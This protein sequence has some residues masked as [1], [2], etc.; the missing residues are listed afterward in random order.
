[1]STDMS[2]EVSTDIN[3]DDTTRAAAL[4][5]AGAILRVGAVARDDADTLTARTYTHPALDDRRVVRLVAGTLGEAEDL[6]LDFLGLAREPDAPEVGQVRR[7]TLG[8]PAWALVNDPANGHHALALV[9][10]MERLARQAK[11][12][13]GAAKDGFEALATRLG[14][15]VPH[16]LPTFYEQAA[17]VFLQHDNSTYA[18]TLFG[19]ARAAER[20]HGLPVDEE[21]Q[22]AVFLEFAFAGALTVKALKDHAQDLSRRLAPAEAWAQFRQLAVE[23][24]GAGMAPYAALPQDARALIKAADLDRETAESAFVGDLIASPSIVRAPASFW[25]AYRPTLV[26]LAAARPEIRIRLL[27]IMPA[28][29]G[30]D[31]KADEAWLSLLAETGADALLTDMRSTDGVDPADW[32]SRWALHRKHGSSS[33]QRCER[34]LALVER[35][36][37]RLRADGRPADLFQGRW[38]AGADLDLLDACVAW[39]IP[40]TEPAAGA[41]VHL[42]LER[43]IGDDTPGRRDLTA[44]AGRPRFRGLLYEALN[45]LNGH[46]TGDSVLTAIAAHPVLGAVLHDWLRD[47]AAEL[48]GA[49]GLPGSRAALRRLSSFRAVAGQ[50]NPEA[51]AAIA[52]YDLAPVLA[53][54]LRAGVLDELGWPALEETYRRLDAD[55]A[56]KNHW[57][58]VA[59]AWPALVLAN[60]HTA[61][62]VGPEGVLLEHE[63]RLPADLDHWRRPHFRYTDGELLVIWA[64]DGKQRA[65]WSTRPAEPFTL[66]GEQLPQWWNGQDVDF[67]SLPL[68]GGGRATG[69][70]TLHAGDTTLPSTR[71]VLGD[72]TGHWR[73]GRQGRD[74]CWVEYDPAGGTHGRASL[75][76]F[77]Q[78]GIRDGA[79]LVTEE[80]EVLPLLPG[81]EA[82]PLGTD[83]TVLG[84]WVRI[85]GEDPDR[86]VT[87]GTPDGRTVTLAIASGRR[88]HPVPLG[89]LRLPG[90]AAPLAALA[91]GTIE[92]YPEGAVTADALG[93]VPLG[94]R[95]G[96]YAAGTRYVPPPAFWHALRPRDER[97]SAALRTVTDAQIATLLDTVATALAGRKAAVA[98]D[99]SYDGPTAD[100]LIETAVAAALPALTDARLLTGVSALVRT[101]AHHRAATAAYATPPQPPHGGK[102]FG[103]GM[104]A[105]HRPVHGDDATLTAAVDGIAAPGGYRYWGRDEKWSGLQQI[106]SVNQVLSGK[107]ADGKPLPEPTALPALGDGWTTETHTVPG[108]DLGWL[109]FLDALGALAYRA[110]APTTTDEHREALLLLLEAVATG[111]LAN[112]V[113]ALRQVLL[114]E[115]D[116]EDQAGK[117]QR[118]GQVLRRGDRTVVILGREHT[119]RNDRVHWLALDHDPEGEFGQIADFTHHEEQ[120]HTPALPHERL[121][122]LIRLVRERGAA[123]WR[124]EA[125]LTLDAATGIGPAQATLLVA[126]GTGEPHAAALELTGLKARQAE[127]AHDRLSALGAANRLALLDALLPAAPADLWESGPDTAAAA[128]TWAE[129]LASLVRLPEDL[130]DVLAGVTIASAEAVLNPDRTAWLSRTTV[131]RLDKDGGL[132]AEDPAAVP[133]RG[134]LTSAV[135]ALSGLAYGLPYGHPLRAHLP[136]GL[137]ALRRRLADP[138]LIL[139]LDVEWTE[140]GTATAL[141]LRT[142]YGMPATGGAGADGLTRLG[143][144]LV[145]RP[146]YG[147][148]EMTLVRTAGLTGADDPVFGLLEGLVGTGRAHS[149]AAVRTLLGDDLEQAVLAGQVPGGFTGY[150]QDP[151]RSVPEL[152]AEVAATHGLGDDAAVLYLQLLALPDPTDR[153]RARWTGWTPGRSKKART[154]LAATGLVLEAKRSRAGRTLFLPCGWHEFKAPAL[155]VETWKEP[156]YPLRDRTRAVPHLPV[157]ALFARAWGRVKNGDAPAFEEL[158]TRATRK[159]RRR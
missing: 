41:N 157:P 39:D 98:A 135:A 158:T 118:L 132:V 144:A 87:S 42:P 102:R 147:D 26:A 88:D 110:A 68:P 73:Q 77:L 70:R 134:H 55:P 93:S 44:V 108:I 5:D 159:G 141:P 54:T 100:Q 1:M 131:M 33:S 137:A 96:E 30:D 150:A 74:H 58:V 27:E 65:Y 4:L 106:L 17:R 32:L 25:T 43:W 47:R 111:P 66:G 143:D 101:A 18:A 155:P 127:R 53:A 146:W 34:T 83:G 64:E 122:P 24:C 124:P 152:V 82:T 23:R 97:G 36:A 79:R 60:R 133:G 99:T 49:A 40:V 19:K 22:R 90:G 84:R 46:R 120:R 13:A 21:R 62:V 119:H 28:G 138:G 140:K 154:E 115:E 20:V 136:A 71:P 121:L 114:C 145:L 130:G 103:D 45:G 148:T 126:A 142:A 92:L 10:D 6:A 3:T 94:D 112:P 11:S 12:R 85:E 59:E 31:R 8:F 37:P 69:G 72:G 116:S 109:P 56:D 125:P 151:A 61:V 107:P 86:R 52:A 117:K 156:L 78:S 139:D 81:L 80:C 128:K 63:L 50:V 7:E 91:G 89:A 16:F 57:M 9:K 76:A 153:D 35:M 123:P 129:R 149:L 15:A 95:G 51:V 104:Y 48:T 14:R 67:P 113:G 75:P 105:D 29:L 2:I 38:H